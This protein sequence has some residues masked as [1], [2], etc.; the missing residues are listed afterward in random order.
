MRVGL[1]VEQPF[2]VLPCLAAQHIVPPHHR[3]RRVALQVSRHQVG[4]VLLVHDGVAVGHVLAIDA[5]LAR[6][7]VQHQRTAVG[8]Q[9]VI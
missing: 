3:H 6:R 5:V 8:R 9:P 2:G 4:A 7:Q 1:V